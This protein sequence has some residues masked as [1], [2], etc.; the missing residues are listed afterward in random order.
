MVYLISI[1]TAVICTMLLNTQ[2]E[3]KS[4]ILLSFFSQNNNGFAWSWFDPSS[5][6][7]R[8]IHTFK[9]KPAALYWEKKDKVIRVIDQGEIISFSA[10]GILIKE[11]TTLPQM[12]PNERPIALWRD[13]ND[14]TLRVATW[15]TVKPTQV[16]DN[17][18]ILDTST[19][20][21]VMSNPEW[22]WHAVVRLFKWEADTWVIEH[23]LA[24]K[25]EAGDTPGLS[26][27]KPFW[28]EQGASNVMLSSQ[29]YC[30]RYD[31]V[32]MGR[33]CDDKHVGENI[34]N[35]FYDF[36]FPACEKSKDGYLHATDCGAVSFGFISCENCKF[37][38]IHLN[39]KGDTLQAMLPI[40]LRDKDEGHFQHLSL[41]TKGKIH[42]DVK[43][44]F[45]FIE[46]Q[47]RITVIDLAAGK[48]IFGKT[49]IDPFWLPAD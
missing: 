10:S 44:R 38:L 15:V 23:T 30:G 28:N 29:K 36:A 13:A 48:V 47:N 14:D 9:E 46:S 25:S 11:T 21:R 27:L 3:A 34:R 2:S 17:V 32:F 33:R 35:G 1:V 19:R 16:L 43:D 41:S 5:N 40:Y 24:T 6:Q 49:A 12:L 31:A 42:I 45:S 22:G 37:D 20:I 8:K 18:I 26:V 39:N 7:T 4:S